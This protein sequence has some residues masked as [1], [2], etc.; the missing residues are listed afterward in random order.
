MNSF[1]KDKRKNEDRVIASFDGA[2]IAGIIT[3]QGRKGRININNMDAILF[4]NNEFFKIWVPFSSW[5]SKM[6]TYFN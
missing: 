3:N 1:L 5:M 4:C 2:G 6:S